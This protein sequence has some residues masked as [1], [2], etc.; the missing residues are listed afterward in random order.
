MANS[1]SPGSGHVALA[2]DEY[3][4]EDRTDEKIQKS[5][6]AD[7]LNMSMW[8]L[9]LKAFEM[10]GLFHLSITKQNNKTVKGFYVITL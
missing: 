3:R 9:M 5:Y 1:V 6:I 8:L 7:I 2:V 10:G 4:N